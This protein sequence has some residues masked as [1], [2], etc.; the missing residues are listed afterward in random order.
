M[1]GFQ[2]NPV[3]TVGPCDLALEVSQCHF[4]CLLLVTKASPDSREET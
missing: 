3:E 1:Q 4:Y 2:E